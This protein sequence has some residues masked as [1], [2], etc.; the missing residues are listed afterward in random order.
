LNALR[1]LI[2]EADLILKT[3]PP[4]PQNRAG[5]AREN[6]KAALAWWMI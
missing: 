6:F 4:L 5:A 2:S 3:T 1:N